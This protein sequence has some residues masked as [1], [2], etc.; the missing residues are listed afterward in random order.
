VADGKHG[1][2]TLADL[3]H[4][5]GP[6]PDT[7]E[8]VT[9]TGG[10][11]LYFAWPADVAISNDQAGR[12]GPGLDVRGEGG[13][14]LAPPTTH[15]NGT[16]YTWEALHDPTDGIAVAPA[17]PW[18]IELLTTEP[19][20]QV[21][22]RER[23]TVVDTSRPGDRF[24]AATTWPD[25]LEPD[26]WQL[27][28]T[29][30]GRGGTYELWTRPGKTVRDGASASL[31]YAG[32]DVLKVFT[33]SAAP[34][35]QERTYD[36]FGYYA[37]TQHGGDIEAA[38]RALAS[39]ERLAGN[40]PIDLTRLVAR[41]LL[42]DPA[43]TG[44]RRPF[45]RTNARHHDEIVD[46]AWTAITEHNTPPR[47]FQRAGGGVRI[48]ADENGQPMLEALRA[49]HVR[50]EL[51]Q[52]ARWT[53]ATKDADIPV[54]PPLNVCAS[55]L[56]TPDRFPGLIGLTELP[57]IHPDGTVH[58]GGYDPESR[59]FH[60]GPADPI[61]PMATA[62]AAALIGDLLADFPFD[63]QADRANAWALLLTPLVRPLVN[64]PVPMALIDAPEP[65]T[66][67]GLLAEIMAIIATGRPAT[68]TTLPPHDDELEK[69][70]TSMLLTGQPIIAFDNLEHTVKSPILAAALTAETWQ[71]R[72]LGS[73]TTVNLPARVTWVATGN[74][75]TVG[76]DLAR[77][78]YRI[79]LDARRPKPW[80]R[81]GFRHTDLRGY[82]RHNR[83]R[84]VSALC[85][86]ITDWIRAGRPSANVAP[87]G[88]FSPWAE[89][90]AGVTAHAGVAGVLGNIDAFHEA[91]DAEAA[92]WEAFLT[93]IGEVTGGREFTAAQLTSYMDTV[94]SPI[95]ATLP[96][97]LADAWGTGSFSKRLGRDLVRRLGRH[98]GHEAWSVRSPGATR[99]KVTLFIVA[100]TR[101]TGT[102]QADSGAN[103]ANPANPA[104]G[105]EDRG[106][107]GLRGVSV[108]YAYAH[109]HTHTCAA[110]ARARMDETNPANPAN[111][112]THQTTQT[113]LL[114]A[115]PDP[116]ALI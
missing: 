59:L 8:T 76:G 101:P 24:N 90:V 53:K 61:E 6:L 105:S 74:N 108:S 28:S 47:L 115:D 66:G 64:G 45:I 106:V 97:T 67:K 48:R 75:V 4:E 36:R 27:H 54:D 69:R 103:P 80:E 73:S 41:D 29:R 10:R 21:A 49:E 46:E 55:V 19:Q 99:M 92:E 60:I 107:A 42:A 111:P 84:L 7:V 32:S 38:A 93:A 116:A 96:T 89:I 56:T 5:H 85:A 12:L 104:E 43:P 88:G 112:A 102:D 50:L 98:Y 78:C 110:H 81:S 39:E 95:R 15:P 23:G 17:P 65:G 109:A 68:L 113:P 71:G 62:D 25:L 82:A 18:L 72:M 79:R 58:T 30:N 2:D 1:D 9:G 63:A 70:I 13:Q 77:R 100:P 11:H 3:E 22:R 83:H 26:G 51:A 14:V 52:A 44:R 33:S 34:L 94:D 86:L 40:D 35:A 57:V 37:A 114:V 31:Y 16:P 87:L 20:A 91:A